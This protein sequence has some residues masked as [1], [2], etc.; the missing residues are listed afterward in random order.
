L[1]VAERD[2]FVQ[3]ILIA[4]AR[5]RTVKFAIIPLAGRPIFLFEMHI[6]DAAEQGFGVGFVPLG[7]VT[8]AKL[9]AL[10]PSLGLVNH[11]LERPEGWLHLAVVGLVL[12][13]QLH[14]IFSLVEEPDKP[15]NLIS[16]FLTK[17][18]DRLQWPILILGWNQERLLLIY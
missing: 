4:D 2:L 10:L 8:A 14:V 3:S 6:A 17:P 7:V 13:L 5:I 18:P 15:V 1:P 16:G 11:T 9:A 12:R